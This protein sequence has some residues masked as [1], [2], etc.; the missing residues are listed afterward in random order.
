MSKPCIKCGKKLGFR[1]NT[2][3]AWGNIWFFEWLQK[4]K[5]CGKSFH[6][7]ETCT[8]YRATENLCGYTT[9]CSNQLASGMDSKDQV[10]ATC[11]QAHILEHHLVAFIDQQRET[12]P[13][14]DDKRKFKKFM[15]EVP[16]C[17][18]EITPTW[19]PDVTGN[20][21]FGQL[22]DKMTEKIQNTERK[23]PWCKKYFKRLQM[24]KMG[25]KITELRKAMET[26]ASDDKVGVLECSNCA[27]IR[28]RLTSGKLR[29]LMDENSVLMSRDG[30]DSRALRDARSAKNVSTARNIVGNFMSGYNMDLSR[31]DL[32]SYASNE[33]NARYEALSAEAEEIAEYESKRKQ[34]LP[35]EIEV[36]Q[37]VL[38]YRH[39][40]RSPRYHES[41]GRK[42]PKRKAPKRKA[43]SEKHTK[44]KTPMQKAEEAK[45]KAQKRKAPLS[46]GEEDP[47][48]ALKLRFAKGEIT[49]E[50]FLEMKSM[51]E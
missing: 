33:A 14:V 43:S 27:E 48:K 18:S 5:S 13:V 16:L 26:E 28:S 51:L 39:F 47:M 9:T 42:A 11:A 35:R 29:R 1:D 2:N 3:L 25:W 37:L 12:P 4:N 40:P 31:S 6:P 45:K 36:E 15:E 19:D 30:S 49:K 46:S 23:C 41:H 34:D 38:A 8:E 50:E 22:Y 7:N 20:E 10:C 21:T 44:W 24:V 17:F 32:T